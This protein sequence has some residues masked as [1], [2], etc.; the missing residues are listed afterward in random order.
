M[1]ILSYHLLLHCPFLY[2]DTHLYTNVK[3][4]QP[5]PLEPEEDSL[6]AAE[7]LGDGRPPRGLG[8]PPAP[9]WATAAAVRPGGEGRG[10]LGW[11]HTQ[12]LDKAPTY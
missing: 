12:M 11:G 3:E 4:R 9:P 1:Y 10:R 8:G 7:G 2:I 6:C 5:A